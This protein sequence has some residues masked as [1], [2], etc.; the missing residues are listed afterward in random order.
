MCNHRECSNIRV[1]ILRENFTKETIRVRLWLYSFYNKKIV[2]CFI[3]EKFRNYE[4]I[5]GFIKDIHSSETCYER[6]LYRIL[7]ENGIDMGI[8]T[9]MPL[10]QLKEMFY[11]SGYPIVKKYLDSVIFIGIYKNVPIRNIKKNIRESVGIL[12]N[13]DFFDL[14]GCHTSKFNRG[15]LSITSKNISSMSIDEDWLNVHKIN[16]FI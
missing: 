14:F 16:N 4:L 1:A 10:H 6:E 9:G 12:E 2:G 8:S 13:F 7:N 3:K 11:F 5:S 15:E